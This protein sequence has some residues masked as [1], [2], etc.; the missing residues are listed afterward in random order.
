MCVNGAHFSGS[1]L[2]S[3]CAK[4]LETSQQYTFGCGSKFNSW[5]KPQVLVFGSIYQGAIL[6]PLF[7]PQPF[8]TQAFHGPLALLPRAHDFRCAKRGSASRSDRGDSHPA[9][10]FRREAPASRSCGLAQVESLSKLPKVG[11]YGRMFGMGFNQC[12]QTSQSFCYGSVWL[13]F[14]YPW[15]NQTDHQ[16]PASQDISWFR[17]KDI[18]QEVKGLLTQLLQIDEEPHRH[19]RHGIFC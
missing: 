7:E 5:G 10:A 4:S 2:A 18:V 15:G 12:S 11:S 13:H 8:T 16:L 14:K 3:S 6:V 17:T 1:R 19:A 9:E